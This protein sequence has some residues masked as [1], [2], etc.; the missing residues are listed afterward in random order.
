ML[1]GIGVSD[2][3]IMFMMPHGMQNLDRFLGAPWIL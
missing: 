1:Y 2:V 3:Q